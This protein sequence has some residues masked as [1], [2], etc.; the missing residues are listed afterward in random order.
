M[1]RVTESFSKPPGF[2]F[3][4]WAV[5]SVVGG[6]VIIVLA[7]SLYDRFLNVRDTTR[8]SQVSAIAGPPCPG[9]TP[10]AIARDGLQIRYSTDFNGL[11]VG[12]RFG[13]VSC[14]EIAAKGGFGVK[15]YPVCQFSGP[16]V[17]SVTTP[18][19]PLFFR[20]GVGRKASILVENGA[21]RC[22]M[23]APDWS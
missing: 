11:T 18:K 14:S 3:P 15:S 21:P 10:A 17:V 9:I 12:R 23:A 13:E 2:R 4:R 7:L 5:F 1:A 8:D 22:V 19:G 20:P 6:G 16:D